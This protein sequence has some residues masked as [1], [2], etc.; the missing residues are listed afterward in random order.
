M[1]LK[2]LSFNFNSFFVPPNMTDVLCLLL[3]DDVGII[4]YD[5]E[6]HFCGGVSCWKLLNLGGS[7]QNMLVGMIEK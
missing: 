6:D 1:N 5:Y 4:L 2:N 7:Y 3:F